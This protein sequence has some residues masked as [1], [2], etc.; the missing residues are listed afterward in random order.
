MVFD[1]QFVQA[2]LPD[3]QI[4]FDVFPS[5]ITLSVDTRTLRAG[6][7]FIAFVGNNS[8]GHEFV[9]H[10]LQKGAAGVIINKV[11]LDILKSVDQKLLSK[12]LTAPAS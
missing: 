3:A 2:V 7:V 4:L 9:V 6:D 5:D 12:K 10:A 1:K 8:D 11:R